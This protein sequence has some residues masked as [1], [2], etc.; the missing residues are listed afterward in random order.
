[1]LGR[2]RAHLLRELHGLGQARGLAGQD[3]VESLLITAAELHIRADLGLVDAAEQAI[4]MA[5]LAA[6]P[7][8][9]EE[10]A[11]RTG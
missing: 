6:A 4:T 10:S 9:R 2:Q 11:R 7:V 5:G 3:P 8:A 1:V